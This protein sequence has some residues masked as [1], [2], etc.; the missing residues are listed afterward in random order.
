MP[1]LDWIGK[2]AVVNHHMQVPYYLLKCDP[3]LSAGDS[4]S[5]NMLVQGDN[6]LAL[7]ALLPYY[8]GE[9][10]C[11]YIDPPYN[12]GK[13]NWV[14]NDNVNAPEIRN[15]LSQVVGKEGDDLSRHDKWLCM[16][17][18]RLQ[19]L[20][21]FL[22]PA[23]GVI[24]VSC[25]DNEVYHLRKIMDDIFGRRNFVAQ[26]VWNTEGHTD[27]QFQVKVNHEYVVTYSSREETTNLGFVIDP[28][29]RK[30]SNLWK[31]YAENSITKNGP[32]NP[33]SE[34]T[35]P[36]GFPCVA[37]E[38]NLDSSKV[39][40][41]FFVKLKTLGYVTRELTEEFDVVYP[42]RIDPLIVNRGILSQPCRVYSGW[43]NVNKLKAFIQN[44]CQPIA[45]EGDTELS[46]YLSERGVIYYKRERSKA[47]NIL[48]VL[49]NFGTTE[50]MRSELEKMGL[51]FQYPKPKELIKYLLNIGM[52]GNS[53][54][55]LDSFAGSGTTAQAVLELN[56]DDGGSRRF[57]LIEIEEAIS[58][59][60]TAERIKKLINGYKI[61]RGVNEGELVAAIGSGF[62][63]CKLGAPLFDEYGNIK[64]EV[65]FNDLAH[66]V[67]FCETGMPLSKNA[68]KGTP[69]IGV[70]NGIAYYLLFNGIMGDKSVSGGN[71]LT[72]KIFERL[73]AHDGPKVVYGGGTRLSA[74]HLRREKIVFRQLPYELKIS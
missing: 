14:Y 31:G 18:P 50:Q 72:S 4:E 26:F 32:G 24:F 51:T 21:K 22:N 27:N 65:K 39:N 43:A 54:L 61:A 73:P 29:I 2:K 3:I 52:N 37:E 19:L 17:Y 58:K 12:T 33:P 74:E 9:V 48:S 34:V 63:F 45:E 5:E 8:A 25:D 10:K 56:R 62:R 40:S 36:A 1:T 38:L 28:N 49:K 60:T 20:K 55:V 23:D 42:I 13:E 11:I 64:S 47:R 44:K 66:H 41:D 35:L 53:G 6:L 30:E 46:F 7:K 59:N 16:M 68:I 69:L 70:H 57:I 67:F 15:W 71:I